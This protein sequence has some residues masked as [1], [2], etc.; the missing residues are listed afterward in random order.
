LDRADTSIE[1]SWDCATVDGIALDTGG[2]MTPWLQANVTAARQIAGLH[3]GKWNWASAE[4]QLPGSLHAFL[5]FDASHNDGVQFAE[6]FEGSFL[7]LR[8]GSNWEQAKRSTFQERM[9]LFTS[10]IKVLVAA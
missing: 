8:A 10:G 1:M 6:L 7:H 2:A 9:N 3:S 5:E 4:V